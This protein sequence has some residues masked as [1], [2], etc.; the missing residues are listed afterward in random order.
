MHVSIHLLK[1]HRIIGH[2]QTLLLRPQMGG[3]QLLIIKRLR[4]LHRAQ[5][6]S[7]RR[8]DFTRFGIDALDRI[9]DGRGNHAASVSARIRYGCKDH[10]RGHKRTRRIVHRHHIR[11][12]RQRAKAV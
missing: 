2:V 6:L 9:Y 11:I 8:G 4:R 5:L 7:I 10:I 1:Q 3:H 12:L